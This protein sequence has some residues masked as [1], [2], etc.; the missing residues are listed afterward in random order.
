M[1][2]PHLADQKV[3]AILARGH[4]GHAAEYRSGL[5][6]VFPQLD[7]VCPAD[8][9]ELGELV[10]SSADSHSLVLA[11]G[12]DGT[13][14]QVLQ[15][16]DLFKQALGILPAGTG[17]DFA[18]V[19]AFPEGLERRIAHLNSL[20]IRPTD[21][22]SVGHIRYHNSAG[23]GLDS[24][25]LRRR[26][27]TQGALR[28]NYT[29]LFLLTLA[30]LRCDQIVVRFDGRDIDGSFYWVLCMNTPYIGGGTK[31]APEAAVDDG[32]LDMILIRETSKLQLLRYLPSA[33]KGKHIGSPMTVHARVESVLCRSEE[34]LDY[35]A[36][37]GELYPWGRQELE[38]R[39][40]PLG[41]RFLR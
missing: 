26:E 14:H 32:K 16:I 29:A 27:R 28:S 36:V 17:N 6:Q 3:L 23:F 41:L 40:H 13:L 31:I 33:I 35:I 9:T 30:G 39:A 25:T 2:H 11:I 7:L 10:R 20:N 8:L 37:D 22:G 18:R 5:S 21:F 1:A 34:R 24:E 4:S 19:L 38:F 12:G 15:H